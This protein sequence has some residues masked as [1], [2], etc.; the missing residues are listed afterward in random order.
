MKAYVAA[1]RV[2]SMAWAVVCAL[3]AVAVSAMVVAL[4]DQLARWFGVSS[5][6]GF[7]LGVRIMGIPVLGGAGPIALGLGYESALLR[8]IP[9]SQRPA[10]DL[11]VSR[12][13]IVA[14]AIAF[15]AIGAVLAGGTYYLKRSADHHF[16]EQSIIKRMSQDNAAFAALSD[17]ERE[18]ETDDFLQS[19]TRYR[20][21]LGFILL[22]Q[23][24]YRLSL[25]IDDN[26]VAEDAIVIHGR[27]AAMLGRTVAAVEFLAI[28]CFGAAISIHVAMQSRNT[29]RS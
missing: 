18:N 28:L 16:W 10:Q 2:L 4:I 26:V 17:R 6:I 22:T 1:R 25:A 27:T 7:V 19:E 21:V 24:N 11:R 29:I 15:G 8:L 3:I 23:E 20:G 5:D 13:H 14:F 9:P 12:L